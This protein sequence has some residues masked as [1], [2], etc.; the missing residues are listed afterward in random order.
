MIVTAVL[1]V[2]FVPREF[3]A[4]GLAV[5]VLSALLGYVEIAEALDAAEND[6]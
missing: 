6:K 5:S 3:L 2:L 4:L 1:L